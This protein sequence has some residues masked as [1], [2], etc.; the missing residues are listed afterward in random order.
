M[1]QFL[2]FFVEKVLRLDLGLLLRLGFD[3]EAVLEKVINARVV[4]AV[5]QFVHGD[6]PK[7]LTGS[8]SFHILDL[9]LLRNVLLQ[10]FLIVPVD[11]SV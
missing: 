8:E 7:V 3:P 9:L 1:R 11:K 5:F 2:L 6:C 4:D 10:V